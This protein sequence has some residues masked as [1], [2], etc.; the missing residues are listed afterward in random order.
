MMTSCLHG[1]HTMQ[2]PMTSCHISYMW[3][4]WNVNHNDII[5]MCF[6]LYVVS[7]DIMSGMHDTFAMH[8]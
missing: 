2:T 3:Q 7:N 6:A 8:N 1:V 4:E 5:L